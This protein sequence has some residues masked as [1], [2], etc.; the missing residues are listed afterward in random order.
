MDQVLRKTTMNLGVVKKISPHLNKK[1]LDML[2]H[3]M[4]V[5]HI[6]YCIT[7]WCNGNKTTLLKIQQIA[8][9]FIRM[10]YG[11][12]YKDSEKNAM[13]INGLMTVEQIEQLE[14]AC[15]MFKYSKNLLPNSFANFFSN[16]LV[17]LNNKIKTRSNSAYS[18]SF[19]RL[20]VTQQCLKY[21]G[22]VVWN[23]IPLKIKE[24]KIYKKFRNELKR[25]ILRS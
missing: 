20:T 22:P 10:I 3:S 19:C 15:C 6:R 4:I 24:L 14:T 5:S 11:I 9:K 1:S 25:H 16:N 18:L 21:R 2:Y 7:T 13:C 23:K 8:N 12:H 17:D